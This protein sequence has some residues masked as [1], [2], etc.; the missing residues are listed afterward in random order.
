MVAQTNTVQ[1]RPCTKRHP[2]TRVSFNFANDLLSG[3]TQKSTP[4]MWQETSNQYGASSS[5]AQYYAQPPPGPTQPIPLQFF[6]PTTSTD[7]SN[8][9]PGARSSL[10]GNLGAQGPISQHGQPPGYGGNIQA[11]GGW[12]TA[13]GTGGFEGEPPLLE[14]EAVAPISVMCVFIHDTAN[15]CI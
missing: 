4:F 5:H 6:A 9:Y 14:G 12:W 13:F 11:V 2:R 3:A 7:P 10:E 8:F 1:Q 15:I